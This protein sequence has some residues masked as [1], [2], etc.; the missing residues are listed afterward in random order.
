MLSVARRADRHRDR[1]GG[2]ARRSTAACRPRSRG[3]RSR[4]RSSSAPRS[5]SSSASIRRGGRR[6]STRSR[7]CGTSSAAPRLGYGQPWKSSGSTCSRKSR[8]SSTSASSSTRRSSSAP[9]P[10][11]GPPRRRRSGAPARTASAIESRRPRVDDARAL[12]AAQDERGVER[13]L[14]DPRDLDA[15]DVGVERLDDR[16][17]A[18]RASSGAGSRRPRARA[19]WRSPRGGRSRW[20]AAAPSRARRRAA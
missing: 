4:S 6:G 19:G 20:A 3:G 16:P 1:L 10:R 5:A 8:N 13:A 18:G 7:R 12:L 17:A 9:P 15:L 2:R 14:V 11:P